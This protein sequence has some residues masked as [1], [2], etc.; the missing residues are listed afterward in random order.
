MIISKGQGNFETLS[1]AKRPIFFLF[2]VKC[3]VVAKETGC[4]MQDIVLL[5]NPKGKWKF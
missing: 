5:F 4:K 2:M 1:R 3:P